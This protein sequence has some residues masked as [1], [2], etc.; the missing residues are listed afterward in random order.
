MCTCVT[1]FSGAGG[2]DLGL[3][4]ADFR[5]VAAF[6]W[7]RDAAATH[8]VNFPHVDLRETD[9]S[10]LHLHDLRGKVGLLW[11]SPPCQDLSPIGTGAA[12][13]SE[14]NQMVFHFARLVREMQPEQF[15][16]EN[17]EQLLTK[18]KADGTLH[19]DELMADLRSD[20]LY[21]V[22]EPR[23]LDAMFY[24][25][26]Q[27]RR[28]VFIVG[29]RRDAGLG[30]FQWPAELTS[31]PPTIAEALQ[32]VLVS[33]SVQMWPAKQKAMSTI[34]QGRAHD[35]ILVVEDE[36]QLMGKLYGKKGGFRTVGRRQHWESPSTAIISTAN[37]KLA[38]QAHA[39]R[40]DSQ[41]HRERARL[42]GFP[43]D[44]DFVGSKNSIDQQIGNAVCPPVA[45][46]LGMALQKVLGGEVD[47]YE[48]DEGRQS[49]GR[50]ARSG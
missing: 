24:G 25:V 26:A 21:D 28:R 34:R 46:H 13:S 16:M 23:V 18:Q 11:G 2:A 40:G 30:R 22:K 12:A 27:T 38:G 47:T 10:R 3:N 49:A 45:Y 8:R 32:G 41:Q 15:V 31:D 9:I 4:W 44:F 7:D 50:G 29:R 39:L 5:I 17:V 20:G 42:M 43:D 48:E 37:G 1:I 6:E 36:K 14:R 35:D 33:D 19:I